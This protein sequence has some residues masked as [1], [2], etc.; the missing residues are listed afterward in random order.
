MPEK[1]FGTF[2]TCGQFEQPTCLII[3]WLMKNSAKT[4]HYEAKLLLLTTLNHFQRYTSTDIIT[5][6]LVSQTKEYICLNCIMYMQ[7]TLS[8]STNRQF[9]IHTT[10]VKNKS[11]YELN[12]LISR[13]S[14]YLKPKNKLNLA[15]KGVILFC[16]ILENKNEKFWKAQI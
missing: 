15:T 13:G 14:T 10:A 8:S 7:V 4:V 9:I 11:D 16:M 1:T 3:S 12:T 6:G 5:I 2:R